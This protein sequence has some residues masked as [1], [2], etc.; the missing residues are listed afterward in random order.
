MYSPEEDGDMSIQ[1]RWLCVYKPSNRVKYSQANFRRNLSQLP[2]SDKR[3]A[4]IALL[5]IGYNC[6]QV[7]SMIS[8]NRGVNRP[9]SN[10]G[11]NRP[12]TLLHQINNYK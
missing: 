6:S 3:K 8:F 10:R 7:G 4:A 1:L 9:G 11:V 5:K 12:G 2:T